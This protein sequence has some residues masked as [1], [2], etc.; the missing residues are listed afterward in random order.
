MSKA[1]EKGNHNSESTLRMYGKYAVSLVAIVTSLFHLYTGAFG[2]FG[3]IAQRSAHVYL[4]AALTFA[5]V[6]FMGRRELRYR[7]V[8]LILI[9][10]SFS[11]MAY[12]ILNYDR[13]LNK[14]AYVTPPAT[15][16][17]VFTVISVILVI[18]ATRRVVGRLLAAVVTLILVGGYY[19]SLLPAP[20]T[21][22]QSPANV[23]VD[24][25]FVTT[26]G[27][28]GIPTRVSAT[29]IFLFVVLAAFL[30][31]T[32]AGRFLINF[33][34]AL[35]GGRQGGAAKVAVVSSSLFGS[36][37]GSAAA[38]V[39]GTGIFTIPMMKKFGYSN[40][41]S[42]AAE[43][44]ASCGGQIMPPIMGAGAFI[45]AQ[46]LGID[47]I[48]IA[49]AAV[50]PALLY[51]VSVYFSVHAETL[52]QG[53]RPLPEDEIPQLREVLREQYDFALAFFVTIILL[54]WMLMQG[55]TIYRAVFL[56]VVGLMLITM[57]S[58]RSRVGVPEL[59]IALDKGARNATQIAMATASASVVLGALN[60]SGIG[61]LFGQVLVGL[62]G[63]D[64]LMLLL[65]VAAFSIILGFGMPTTAAYILAAALLGP[66][67]VAVN[68]GGLPAQFYIFT[69]AVYSTITPPVALA[70]FAAGQ[71]A[72]ADPMR[73]ALQ[74]MKMVLPTFI[75]PVRYIFRPAIL[76]Q[77]PMI[78]VVIDT[79]VLIVAVIAIQAG[80]WG[81]PV[82]DKLSRLFA[83]VASILLLLPPE[84]IPASDL[85]T[86]I[87]AGTICLLISIAFEVRAKGLDTVRSSI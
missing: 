32:G 61:V 39:Y 38:N 79:V 45:M 30:E 62:A 65:L 56:S 81:W 43:V 64:I 80:L 1:N 36:L 24:G 8:D 87:A 53:I 11:G 60:T 27:L 71:V 44:S 35:V 70:A 17:F 68:M 72:D 85:W 77:M 2:I 4:L 55:Y 12:I 7:A 58:P 47:Y 54:F 14:T 13:L 51:Y 20:F 46:F 49:V 40:K 52:T 57:V 41:F 5:V 83:L 63:G 23:W 9:L 78:D 76:L 50:I 21:S 28:W 42:G 16:D 48:V 18:E 59:T 3:S 86:L 26:N 29:F 25:L 34:R 19:S 37:S 31:V 75:I 33:A 6:P 10:L 84:I 66:A 15:L 74:A 67:L 73:V 22:P 69:F 82:R